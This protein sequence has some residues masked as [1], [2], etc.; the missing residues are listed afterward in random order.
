V[1]KKTKVPA[2]VRERRL[3]EKKHRGQLKKSRTESNWKREWSE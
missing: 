2:G 3:K 1:R